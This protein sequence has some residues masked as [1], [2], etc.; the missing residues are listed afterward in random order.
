MVGNTITLADFALLP[1]N[2]LYAPRLLPAGVD[3]EERYP[4]VSKWQ[5]RVAERE[6]VKKTLSEREEAMKKFGD[7]VPV[8]RGEKARMEPVYP[9]TGIEVA[10]GA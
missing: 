5:R 2:I 10:V 1:Y 7:T 4:N 6:S 8:F 9:V 3:V